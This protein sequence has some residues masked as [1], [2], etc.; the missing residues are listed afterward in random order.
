[1]YDA[2]DFT[3]RLAQAIRGV[4]RLEVGSDAEATVYATCWLI[5]DALVIAPAYA[6][7]SPAAELGQRY[8]CGG[9]GATLEFKLE[10]EV[11]PAVLRLAE[12]LPGAAL[13]LGTR[14]PGIGDAVFLLHHPM[15]QAELALSI[16][17]L[18]T[19]TPS[20]VRYSADT[21]FGSG[22][23][24]LFDATWAV[25]G[26][27]ALARSGLGE[28]REGVALTAILEALR[29][30]P[31]WAEIAAH[32]GVV[33][34]S[35]VRRAMTVEARHAPRA[36]ETALAAAVRWS[37]D[38]KELPKAAAKELAPLVAEPRASSWILTTAARTSL[39]R[40][41]GSLDALRDARGDEPAAD[42]RQAV[43]DR[44]LVGPPYDL[45]EV[46]EPELPFWLQ[47]SRW[48]ADVVPGLPTPAEIDRTLERRRV[49][50]RLET[51]GGAAFRGREAELAE[52]RTW[53]GSGTAGALALT[54][55]G[56]IG[57]SALVARFALDLDPT[58]LILWLD[59][60]RADLAPDDAVSVLR[61]LLEQT[62]TQLDGF[63]ASVI[64][65]RTWLP[66]LEGLGELLATRLR[67]APPPLLV[68]DGFE[69]AQHAPE[70]HEIWVLLD[71]L[72]GRVPDLRV[73]VSGRA[74][75]GD[76]TLRGRAV[77][78][79]ALDG[80]TEA[81]AAAWLREAGIGDEAIVARLVAMTG[82]IPLALRL[83]VRLI[84]AGGRIEE[85]PE[86]LPQALMQG[87]LYQ[88]ILDRVLDPAL[89]EVA[90]DALVLRRVTPEIAVAL[91]AERAPVELPPAE[92]YA[93]LERELALVG[94]ETEAPDVALPGATVLRLR[95]EVRVA[96]L[97]LLE[98]RDVDR[99]RRMDRRAADWY[100]QF[101]GDD[102]VSAAE[103]VYHRL[104]LSDLS[105]ARDAWRRGCGPLLA[106]AVETLPEAA[107]GWLTHQLAQETATARVDVRTWELSAAER[108]R[109][110]L[111]RGV[112][113]AVAPVLEERP[114]RSDD[115]PLILYDAWIRWRDDDCDGARHFL[116]EAP[117][118]GGPIGR[119]RAVL[120]AALAAATGEPGAADARLV[121]LVDETCWDERPDPVLDA[122]AITGARI[123]LTI[124]VAAELLLV[125]RL[126][127]HPHVSFGVADALPAWD[128]VTPPLAQWLASRSDLTAA[129]DTLPAPARD[130]EL[131]AFA[132]SIDRLRVGS[133]GRCVPL[134]EERWPGPVIY[135]R[136]ADPIAR[137][138]WQRWR[139]V[140]QTPF[141]A[142]ACDW[143]DETFSTGD[144][145]ALALTG[146][147]APFAT[148]GERGLR[149]TRG[150]Q[151]LGSFVDRVWK[152]QPMAPLPP[153]SRLGLAARM[154]GECGELAASERLA[155]WRTRHFS[156]GLADLLSDVGRV[157]PEVRWLALHL[158][159]P[160][161]LD[162]LVHAALGLPDNLP[163][164][165]P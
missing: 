47:A 94:H 30:S 16:G 162:A 114:T 93:R 154:L 160:S 163:L 119:D 104:R 64:D 151:P 123:W 102:A 96:T 53:Y 143:V 128:V 60:D 48:F 132:T 88:R 142:R 126:A 107:A 20:R 150:D 19:R 82:G 155:R 9:V 131:A 137:L 83:A 15:E 22:G 43:I 95:P 165:D 76:V 56:G 44:I 91:L 18:T 51:V 58:P 81:D 55:I 157:R 10:D 63:T 130:L 17:T 89:K 11:G 40:G 101:G 149:I 120:D 141:L 78:S 68:L 144:T 164:V 111:A 110:L 69:V 33:D 62:A 2:T 38:P 3:D 127:H 6:L 125:E 121:P 103:L 90:Q 75:V 7:G 39:L 146:V 98:L 79:L 145:R 86:D 159:A 97:A 87:F 27:H 26:M 116:R 122:V 21:G 156:G 117:D 73:L 8:T 112:L 61:P 31:V 72:V 35:A 124:D 4:R 67:G 80:L 129:A 113:H 24:P 99:V 13:T 115:S 153:P 46:A 106:D 45:D 65:E 66:E 84:Q 54:G 59:F 32:Q 147:L 42:E 105:G 1:M 37:F 23:A 92:I 109:E 139:L 133:G 36:A 14:E 152:T 118:P 74:P 50:S 25:V 148:L 158:L 52:L 138:G 135:E 136:V 29:G 85:V 34:V 108:I 49:R 100:A 70:H 140:T 57:K 41:A 77:R 134:T 12:P 5:T 161:P 71:R 28:E